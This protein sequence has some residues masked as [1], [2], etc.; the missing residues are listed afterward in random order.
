MQL[1]RMGWLPG[2]AQVDLGKAHVIIAGVRR[3]AHF[4]CM[5]LPHS[6]S[7]FV[8]AFNAALEPVARSR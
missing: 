1:C 5:D 4:F 8:K 3:K 7:C 6:D 2:H